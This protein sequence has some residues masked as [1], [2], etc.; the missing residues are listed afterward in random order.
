MKKKNLIK[1]IE[2]LEQQNNMLTQSN[3]NTEKF[4]LI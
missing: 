2:E 1:Q 3:K 4:S